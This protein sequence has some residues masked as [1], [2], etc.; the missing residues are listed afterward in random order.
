M[1]STKVIQRLFFGVDF[2]ILNQCI[3][4]KVRY[5]KYEVLI[6]AL[7]GL[8]CLSFSMFAQEEQIKHYGLWSALLGILIFATYKIYLSNLH[9]ALTGKK[10]GMV[11]WLV[12]TIFALGNAYCFII[13][14][15]NI[16]LW[17][18]ISGF[19]II[20]VGMIVILSLVLY[21]LPVRFN[22]E[23]DSLYAK[24]LNTTLQEEA[25]WAESVITDALKQETRRRQTQSK[26][27]NQV[28]KLDSDM[29]AHEIANA[30]VRIAK[31]I[32]AQWEAKQKENIR[33]N[34][35]AFIK[36]G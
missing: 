24:M 9:I 14:A 13:G 2:N 34:P 17:Q 6:S 25:I 19:Q 12:A 30:R 35:E 31:E 21:Y 18:Y 27:N 15:F 3:D 36:I 33:N 23:E 11:Q 26:L 1:G 5:I 10:N 28:E 16:S 29:I 7:T 20:M 22:E 4:E 8:F 32:L